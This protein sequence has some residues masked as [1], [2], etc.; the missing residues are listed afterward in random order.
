MGLWSFVKDAGASLFGS[1]AE[2]SEL[3]PEAILK[4]EVENLG[5]DTTG[6]EIKVEGDTIEV[7]SD[8]GKGV[9]VPSRHKAKNVGNETYREILVD[10][11]SQ[12]AR[13]GFTVNSASYPASFP[14]TCSRSVLYPPG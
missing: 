4:K 10:G 9:K 12:V 14:I 7:M 11:M 8:I 5:L 6:L 1:K 3:E 13:T 2:A